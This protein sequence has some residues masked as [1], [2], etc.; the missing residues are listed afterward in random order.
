MVKSSEVKLVQKTLGDFK[1]IIELFSPNST[2]IRLMW[3][4]NIDIAVYIYGDAPGGGFGASWESQVRVQYYYGIRGI[5]LE[6]KISIINIFHTF[7][8]GC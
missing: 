8:L 4:G 7:V 3:G 5:N 1:Y 2:P 6:D